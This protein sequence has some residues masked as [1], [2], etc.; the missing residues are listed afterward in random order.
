[1]NIAVGIFIIILSSAF[2]FLNYFF[3]KKFDLVSWFFL[4][5]A[6]MFGGGLALTSFYFKENVQEGYLIPEFL[7]TYPE[8]ALEYIPI[9]IVFLIFCFMGS[10]SASSS[11]L[12]YFKYK[13]LK[14]N[15]VSNTPQFNSRLSFSAFVLLFIS[16]S[17]YYLYVLPYGGFIEY[18]AFSAAVRS[19]VMDSL[20]NNPFS[21]LIA[22]GGYSF[23][24]SFIY[25]SFLRDR[26]N[27]LTLSF[28]LVSFLFSLYVLTSWLGRITFLFYILVFFLSYSF[29]NE[30]LQP[31]PL[32]LVLIFSS[33]FS[34]L[35][36]VNIFLDR[37]E[38]S[39]VLQML[40]LELIFPISSLANA[41]SK[42]S[43]FRLGLDLITLPLFWTPQRFWADYI[44]PSDAVNTYLLFG[45]YKGQAG[46]T[47][48]VPCDILTLS[49][50]NFS[51]A[52][53]PIFGFIV[54]YILQCTDL[55]IRLLK[56]SHFRSIIYAYAVTN[57]AILTTIYA[58]PSHIA[59][60]LF[61]F[62]GFLLLF[63]FSKHF[64]ILKKY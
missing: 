36:T 47:G 29:K 42:F 14:W 57:L 50:I 45:S 38:Y 23:F 41:M 44:T 7:N 16:L 33:A 55:A 28:F 61:P 10:Y 30:N 40:S 15:L 62:V 48:A 6:F 25:F 5:F 8:F 19:G 43:E 64:F 11:R 54:G 9:T 46:N 37:G 35:F 17:F 53:F 18:L 24:A 12:I 58:D 4:S 56:P 39:D 34:M 20:P 21:F 26:F 1:M 59:G 2:S 3:T 32:F 63:K 52:G 31:R 22:F 60:R 27:I 49:Y 51:Y 13:I